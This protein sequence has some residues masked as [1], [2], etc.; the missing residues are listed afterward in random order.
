MVFGDPQDPQWT[1]VDGVHRRKFLNPHIQNEGRARALRKVVP[2]L[3]VANLVVF[4]GDVEFTADRQKNVIHLA[5]LD[6]YITKFE[7]GPSK[8]DDWNAIWLTVKSSV[9]TDEESRKDFDAQLS[10]G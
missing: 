4:T 1:N 7:L 2:N 3:P 10:F 9:L 6:S 8:V 5:E